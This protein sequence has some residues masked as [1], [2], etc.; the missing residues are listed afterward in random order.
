MADSPQYGKDV[1]TELL[2]N[3]SGQIAYCLVYGLKSP[4]G[5]DLPEAGKTDDVSYHVLMNGYP[6]KTPES[7]GVSNRQEAHYATQ[8]ALWN[9]LARFLLMNYSSRMWL[10]K[11]RQRTLF[12]RQIKARIH[13]MSG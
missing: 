9:A 11:K 10:L 13:K 6:Q 5:E 7:L 12:M 4:N 3:A 2:K 1:R 8:L